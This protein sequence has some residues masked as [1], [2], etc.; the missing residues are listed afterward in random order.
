MKPFSKRV[1]QYALHFIRGEVVH[2]DVS[3]LHHIRLPTSKYSSPLYI[4]LRS[5]AEHT[6]DCQPSLLMPAGAMGAHKNVRRTS[7]CVVPYRVDRL[8]SYIAKRLTLLAAPPPPDRATLHRSTAKPKPKPKNSRRVVM[9]IRQTETT[10]A[11]AYSV[12][13]Y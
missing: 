10:L 12:V 4:V 13:F 11:V 7:I 8:Y 2:P 3:T 9:R 5:P 1:T 6:L